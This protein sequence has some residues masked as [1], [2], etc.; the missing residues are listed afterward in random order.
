MTRYTM[1]IDGQ[2][3]SSPGT[4]KVATPAKGQGPQISSPW[5]RL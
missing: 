2:L 3:A 5:I 4:L 1:T